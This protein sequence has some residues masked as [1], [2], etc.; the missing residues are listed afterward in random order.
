[1][2]DGSIDALGVMG[3]T[4]KSSYWKISSLISCLMPDRIVKYDGTS[5]EI[6]LIRSTMILMNRTISSPF[7]VPLHIY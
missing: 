5:L 2:V 4:R 7:G 6:D 3:E 1:M